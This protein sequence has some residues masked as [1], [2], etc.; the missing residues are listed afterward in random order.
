MSGLCLGPY[1]PFSF[2]P[3]DT[4]MRISAMHLRQIKREFKSE[5]SRLEWD[6]KLEG[7]GGGYILHILVM[8]GVGKGLVSSGQRKEWEQSYRRMLNILLYNNIERVVQ[9]T[10]FYFC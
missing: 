2:H 5:W 8:V 10:V 3:P 1:A 6:G 7:P 9:G 4:P